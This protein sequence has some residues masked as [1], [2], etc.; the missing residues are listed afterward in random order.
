MWHQHHRRRLEHSK[1]FIHISASL[2]TVIHDQVNMLKL[3][4][5]KQTIRIAHK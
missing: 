2:N 4:P 1:P 3:R 5:G